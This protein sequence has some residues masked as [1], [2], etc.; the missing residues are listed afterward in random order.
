MEGE[1]A[2]M[3]FLTITLQPPGLR[4]CKWSAHLTQWWCT[5]C[6]DVVIGGQL[7]MY[8]RGSYTTP[9]MVS[10]ARCKACTIAADLKRVC[11]V[12]LNNFGTL[13]EG[14]HGYT[15]TWGEDVECPTCGWEGQTPDGLNAR[16]IAA[17]E[18]SP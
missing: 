16:T 6:R 4:H 18:A 9:V 8:D 10:C 5:H 13:A 3:G 14:I 2:E 17:D 12:C 7:T 15:P 11:P 1:D